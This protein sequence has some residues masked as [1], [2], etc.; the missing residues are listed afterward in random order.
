MDLACPP[1]EAA[2]PH[3]ARR[4]ADA[5]DDHRAGP[6]QGEAAEPLVHSG[7]TGGDGAVGLIQEEGC[8]GEVGGD[9]I[10][11][12]GQGPQLPAHLR[13]IGA[14]D[15]AVVAHDRIDEEQGVR[16]AEGAD[17]LSQQVDLGGGAQ[18]AAVD[19]VEVRVERLPVDHGLLHHRC[20]VVKGGQLREGEGGVSGQHRGGQRAALGAHD[21]EDGQ[22]DGERTAAQ[23][24]QIMDGGHSR[25]A[26]HGTTSK[27]SIARYDT[28]MRRPLEGELQALRH[29][30]E[31]AAAR[32]PDK[33]SFPL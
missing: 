29:A 33:R 23:P 19:G 27:A 4:E 15:T 17:E 7:L 11:L 10:G 32:P 16:P 21:R 13:G 22:G 26:V 18:E 25:G 5:C 14:V 2:R 9:D 12:G 8:L 3:R 20:Q 1:V 24:G 28:A 31:R 30:A 6:I